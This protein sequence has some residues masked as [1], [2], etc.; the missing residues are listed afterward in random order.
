MAMSIDQIG[1]MLEE[2]GL[3]Y[4][5]QD[6]YIFLNMETESYRDA[7]KSGD[8]DLTLMIEL[9]EDGEYFTLMAPRAYFVNGKHQ[10]A[11]MEVCTR[12]QW[13]TK[14]VQFEWDASDGEVRPIIEI[15]LEDNQL[16]SR[17]LKRCIFGLTSIIDQ[18]HE[19][20]QR[21]ATEGV[22]AMPGDDAAADPAAGSSNAA[23]GEGLVAPDPS[24]LARVKA[25]LA[26]RSADGGASEGGGQPARGEQDTGPPSML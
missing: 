23:A 21:A 8:N 19:V 11:F 22:I 3:S 10:D 16:T 15:P 24:F 9:L 5:R 13:R 4:Q 6:D 18:Y 26:A 14:L 1:D 25:V 2:L 17:Q 7:E 20:M 12:I